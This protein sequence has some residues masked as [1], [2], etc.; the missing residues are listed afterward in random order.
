MPMELLDEMN[1]QRFPLEIP[2]D[3]AIYNQVKVN[4]DINFTLPL[5]FKLT[6]N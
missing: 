3:L 1:F 4:L 2:E 5:M 6:P